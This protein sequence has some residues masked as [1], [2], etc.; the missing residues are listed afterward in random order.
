MIKIEGKKVVTDISEWNTEY[1]ILEAI[2]FENIIVVIF[3]YMEFPKH[4]VARNLYNDIG[5]KPTHLTKRQYF[6]EQGIYP[7]G[8]GAVFRGTTVG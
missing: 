1:T 4:V 2:E 3:D 8:Q 5:V 6:G 7:K